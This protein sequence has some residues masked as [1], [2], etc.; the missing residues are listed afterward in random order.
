MDTLFQDEATDADS[1]DKDRRRRIE[2][3]YNGMGNDP[4]VDF[5][6]GCWLWGCVQP[7]Q[8]FS[9]HLVTFLY[10]RENL[11]LL[12]LVMHQMIRTSVG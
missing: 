11:K 7:L 5:P 3:S 1:F 6:A 12:Q 10:F 4:F 8:R 9:S 2:C